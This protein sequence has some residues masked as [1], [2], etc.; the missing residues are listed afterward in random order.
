MAEPNPTS[1]TVYTDKHRTPFL[2]DA[3]DYEAVSRYSW[4]IKSGGYPA[5]SVGKFRSAWGHTRLVP[6]HVFLMGHAPAGMEWDHI[7]RDKLDNR[8]ANL[9]LVQPE[10]NRRNIGPTRLNKSGRRGVQRQRHMWRVRIYVDGRR[11]EVGSY[12]TLDE[13]FTARDAAERAHWGAVMS[14]PPAPRP[15]EEK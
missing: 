4:S 6:L 13:A 9:R 15:P 14:G 2:I 8:R 11:I 10:I 3:D 12:S 7:N 5:T 1:V